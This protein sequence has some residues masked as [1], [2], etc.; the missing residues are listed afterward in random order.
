MVEMT[1]HARRRLLWTLNWAS[2]C[3][4]ALCLGLAFLL[5]MAVDATPASGKAVAKK[6]APPVQQTEKVG[7]LSRYAV[8][9]ARDLRKPLFDAPVKEEAKKPKRKLTVTLVG[10][11]VDPG[12]TY[13]FFSDAGGKVTMV[14]VGQKIDGAEVT[15]VTEGSATLNLDGDPVTLTVAKKD[16]P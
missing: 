6:D 4:I 11:A 1:F 3:G 10:T 12:S 15:A 13:A 9:Y 5:P 16:K 7:P 8:V 2:V 14:G